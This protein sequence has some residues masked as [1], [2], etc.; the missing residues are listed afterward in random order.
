[1]TLRIAVLASTRGTDL[2]AIMDEM[3]AGKLD[4][5][6]ALVLTNKQCAAEERARMAG[7]KTKILTFDK[8]KD[9]RESYDRK[10]SGYLE[11]EGVELI[12]LVGWMRL[13]SPWFVKRY[14]NRIMNVHPSLLPSFPG[15][16]RAVHEEVLAYGCKV[17]GC[18]IHFVDEGT[19]TGPIIMQGTVEI[20]NDETADT[21]KEKVQ[22]LERR[23]YPKAIRLYAEGKLT[24]NGR[25]VIVAD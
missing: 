15:M 25:K 19:D 20:A 9:T 7:Y 24:V 8:E 22:A 5:E 17:S 4:A 13:F 14:A 23:L 11:E 16:D 10:V 21:L 18:T 2:Q 12:V 3:G 6:L 1:M